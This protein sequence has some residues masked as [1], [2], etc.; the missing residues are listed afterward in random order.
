MAA[1]SFHQLIG[2][3]FNGVPQN[4]DVAIYSSQL[5][6]LI[7]IYICCVAIFLIFHY[8]RRV[9]NNNNLNSQRDKFYF[10]LL[11]MVGASIAVIA[12]IVGS[13]LLMADVRTVF[14]SV[15]FSNGLLNEM[16]QI[17]FT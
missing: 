13:T 17:C 12:L 5:T 11:V 15:S 3:I 10:Y 14:A 1:P 4:E 2:A 16:I 7:A 9:K 6:S 8:A